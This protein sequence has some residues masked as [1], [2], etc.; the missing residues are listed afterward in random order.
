MAR[1]GGGL[2]LNVQRPVSLRRLGQLGVRQFVYPSL[3]CFNYSSTS[4]NLPRP[5]HIQPHP[6]R[7][8]DY[9][10]DRRFDYNLEDPLF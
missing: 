8:P 6:R 10:P 1:Q 4:D 2:F 7:G 5:A 3:T 9:K